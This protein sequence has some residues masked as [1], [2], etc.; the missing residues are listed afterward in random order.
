MNKDVWSEI[1]S[2]RRHVFLYV[3]SLNVCLGV[4]IIE[5]YKSL[6]NEIYVGSNKNI[7]LHYFYIFLLGTDEEVDCPS[8][9]VSDPSQDILKCSYCGKGF[10]D[11]HHLE[12]HLRT[13]TGERAYVC[14][15]CHTVFTRKYN[16]VTHRRIHTGDKRFKCPIC[17]YATVKSSALTRHMKTHTKYVC[18]ICDANFDRKDSLIIHKKKHSLF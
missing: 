18:D 15:V 12:V 5:L 3:C 6:T 11:K 14:D 2:I 16:L 9:A 10:W 1:V 17:D 4:L 8:S 7:I 13:H